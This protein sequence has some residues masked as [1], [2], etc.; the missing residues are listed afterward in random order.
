MDGTTV[1]SF[2]MPDSQVNLSGTFLQVKW[3]EVVSYEAYF[4]CR[5]RLKNTAVLMCRPG[6]G[7]SELCLYCLQYQCLFLPMR[8][9][10]ITLVAN[11]STVLSSS[12]IGTLGFLSEQGF[13][14]KQRHGK[15]YGR[16]GMR[17]CSVGRRGGYVFNKLPLGE[18]MNISNLVRHTGLLWEFYSRTFTYSKVLKLRNNKFI[19]GCTELDRDLTHKIMEEI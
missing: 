14:S 7:D 9:F 16:S 15:T 11:G 5:K 2:G 19:P 8:L 10:T 1:G 12:S 4:W 13:V 6:L 3:E 18:I 17:I